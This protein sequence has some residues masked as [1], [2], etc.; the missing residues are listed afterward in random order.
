MR[1]SLAHPAN[2]DPTVKMPD[3]ATADVTLRRL[4]QFKIDPTKTYT[5]QETRDGQT[6]ASG[7]VTPDAAHLLTI[8]QV[9]ITVAPSELSL[10]ASP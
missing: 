7:K 5:W 10:Q 8:P 3:T 6:I 4:Q 1:L 2:L 9:T